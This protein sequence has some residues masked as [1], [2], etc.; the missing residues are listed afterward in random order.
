V[1]RAGRRPSRRSERRRHRSVTDHRDNS[2]AS[3]EEE[4]IVNKLLLATAIAAG[5]S[6]CATTASAP[7]GLKDGAFSSF[8]CDGVD[9]QARWSA[10]TDTIRVRTIHGSAELAPG[11]E[12]TSYSGDG[13]ILNLAGSDGISLSHAGKVVG[14]N[15]KRA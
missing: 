10:D 15:C 1:I 7:A 14:K 5:L 3:I 12:R 11:K 9:F 8:D 13:Y 4:K 2:I 6:A